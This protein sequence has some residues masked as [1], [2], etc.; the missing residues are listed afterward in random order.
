MTDAPAA[1]SEQDLAAA[2]AELAEGRLVP[3]WFTAAAVGVPVGGSA[4]IVSIGEPAEGDF[5]EVRPT[6]SKD[7]VFCSPNELTT[8]RPPRRRARKAAEAAPAPAVSPAPARRKA[9]AAPKA[10][11]ARGQAASAAVEPEKPARPEKP[12]KTEKAGKTEKVE[13]AEKPAE[14][15]PARARAAR[16]AAEVTVTLTS[17]ADGE[18]TVEVTSGRKRTVRPTPVQPADVAKAA[19]SLPAAVA[20]AIDASLEAARQRQLERVERLRAELDAAQRA[21]QELSG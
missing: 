20:E 1:L 18:W 21:L 16:Q 6:G 3:V 17:T 7:T 9:V 8:T 19:R 10:E 2:R 11:P 14:K 13:Q 12:E 4:K 15:K 5:I